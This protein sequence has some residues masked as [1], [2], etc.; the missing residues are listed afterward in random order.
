MKPSE[1]RDRD[2]I[3]AEDTEA[4]ERRAELLR[5][6]V[7]VLLTEADRRRHAAVEAL[8]VKR[9]VRLHPAITLGVLGGLVVLAIA[10]PIL[11]VRR[12]RKRRSVKGRALALREA[13]GRMMKRPERV[14]ENPPHLPK[15]VL[16][17]ALSAA[18]S[19]FAKK[20]VERL[21]ALRRARARLAAPA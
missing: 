9:Q 13:M 5:H 3:E 8:N 15:K 21:F 7:D 6:N 14:A 12:L 10:L 19:S 17:A 1:E 20:E 4:L 16:A 2:E 11:G 18:A